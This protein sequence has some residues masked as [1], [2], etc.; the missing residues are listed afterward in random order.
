M[1][2]FVGRCPENST[3]CYRYIAPWEIA[4][5]VLTVPFYCFHISV[6]IF[7]FRQIYAGAPY[8]QSAFYRLFAVLSIADILHSTNIQLTVRLFSYGI[9][10]RFWEWSSPFLANPGYLASAYCSYV[11]F[12]IH[13]LMA[14]N[15]F[16]AFAYSQQ[17]G[18]MWHPRR[19]KWMIL[20]IVILPLF[21][22]SFR[23]PAEAEFFYV[24]PNQ[25]GDHYKNQQLYFFA[26]LTSALLSLFTSLTSFILEIAAIA[27]FRRHARLYPISNQQNHDL[28]LLFCSII[29]LIGQ[30]LYTAFYCTVIYA[31]IIKN[32]SIVGFAQQHV[33][34]ILDIFCLSGPV[35][36][37]LSSRVIRSLYL[38]FYR[39]RKIKSH[40]IVEMTT[41]APNRIHPQ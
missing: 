14:I 16:T 22:M 37:M 29:M 13:T 8:F 23:F 26:G 24:A 38:D 4:D 28:R 32:P 15:R 31:A 18:K 5:V 12:F 39:I 19:V 33:I 36:L 34:W 30:S 21:F 20:V 9:F 3:D 6:T 27:A 2:K 40:I 10:L 35:C 11:Q 41:S 25:M 17:Y 7:I 1:S